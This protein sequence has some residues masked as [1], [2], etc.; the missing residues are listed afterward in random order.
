MPA[1]SLACRRS[2][3][4]RPGTGRLAE[5]R[6]RTRPGRRELQKRRRRAGAARPAPAP[7]IQARRCRE[8]PGREQLE[9]G[10]STHARTPAGGGGGSA[11]PS[12]TAGGGG[13]GSRVPLPGL[14]EQAK[15]P[16]QTPTPPRPPA[17]PRHDVSARRRR[18]GGRACGA[19]GSRRRRGDVSAPQPGPA[20]GSGASA[21]GSATATARVT[22]PASAPAAAA[23]APPPGGRAMFNVESLE[24]AELGESLLTWVSPARPGRSPPPVPFSCLPGARGPPQP[25]RRRP[26]LG[27]RA[28][29]PSLSRAWAA[30]D[31]LPGWWRA[32]V[33][34]PGASRPSASP[35]LGAQPRCLDSPFAKRCLEML[36]AFTA[37]SLCVQA[38]PGPPGG[39]WTVADLSNQSLHTC[40]WPHFPGC[41]CLPCAAPEPRKAARICLLLNL[42]LQ[43]FCFPSTPCNS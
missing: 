23:A 35:G 38:R 7:A 36:L 12:S 42:G 25:G 14:R 41:S 13:N 30:C 32:N 37:K 17:P 11:R 6:A 21:T 31:S 43:L 40:I 34:L 4:E 19:G 9:E 20:P 39:A 3:P 33:R 8:A 26:A 10:V 15:P 18:G 22:R 5:G 24:R 16:G 2:E 27:G 29:P 1:A 28:V